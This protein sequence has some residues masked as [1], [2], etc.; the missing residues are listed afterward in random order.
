[1]YNVHPGEDTAPALLLLLIDLLAALALLSGVAARESRGQDTGTRNA[2]SLRCQYSYVTGRDA[3]VG[4]DRRVGGVGHRLG[5]AHR[6]VLGV[7]GHVRVARTGFA[8]SKEDGEPA[9]H[10]EETVSPGS[11][12]LAVRGVLASSGVGVDNPPMQ[13]PLCRRRRPN[14][15][16]SAQTRQRFLLRV[17]QAQST[18]V[19]K[20]TIT[21][22]I[23]CFIRAL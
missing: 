3:L 13:N 2:V 12:V 16:E 23:Q 7:E 21:H 18:S 5:V 1:M 8:E 20:Q 17:A 14:A 9:V 22:A 4:V 15:T 10:K 19:T 6:G 11:P